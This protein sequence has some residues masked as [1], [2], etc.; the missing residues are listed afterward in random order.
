MYCFS[1]KRELDPIHSMKSDGQTDR[2]PL[3][4]K[5]LSRAKKF[6]QEEYDTGVWTG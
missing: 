3:A 1:F 6:E 2:R 4:E 5:A